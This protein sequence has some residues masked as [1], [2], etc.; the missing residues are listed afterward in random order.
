MFLRKLAWFVLNS[1][2]SWTFAFGKPSSAWSSFASFAFE[3]PPSMLKK[4][5]WSCGG[6]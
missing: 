3:T 1:S 4:T 5:N 6:V 2:R